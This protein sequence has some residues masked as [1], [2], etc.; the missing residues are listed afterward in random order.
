[1]T[2]AADIMDPSPQNCRTCHQ[3]HTTY[4]NADYALT[5]TAPFNLWFSGNSVDFGAGTLCA[6]C[7]QGRTL[8]STPVLDGTG[9]GITITNTRFNLHHSPVANILGGTGMLEIPGNATYPGGPNSHGN[10]AVNA[11][12]CVTCHMA[13]AFGASAGG[14]SLWMSYDYHGSEVDN[15]AGCEGCHSTISDFGYAGVQDAVWDDVNGD[16]VVDAGSDT[17]WL[18]QLKGLLITAGLLNAGDQSQSGTW[19][20]NQAAAL[21]NYFSI[22][23]DKS[24]GVHNPPY[25]IAL[26]KNSIEALGGTP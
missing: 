11:D 8:S 1:M 26:L 5:T 4:T 9:T 3:I 13:E 18:P 12:G 17:G 7:H 14:H 10:T 19:T 25:V 21:V 23:E 20:D 6:N 15:I 22:W 2:T 24:K 16:H